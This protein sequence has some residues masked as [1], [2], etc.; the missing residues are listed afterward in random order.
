[1]SLQHFKIADNGK[2]IYVSPSTE[3]A[4]V[5]FVHRFDGIFPS[6]RFLVMNLNAKGFL[7]DIPPVLNYDH[8]T[9]RLLNNSKIV[10]QG[11]AVRTYIA[12]MHQSDL[13]LMIPLDRRQDGLEN[14]LP[15]GWTAVV[16]GIDKK[17]FDPDAM[18]S[19]PG[20]TPREILYQALWRKQLEC[21]LLDQTVHIYKAGSPPTEISSHFFD[22][23]TSSR[24]VVRFDANNSVHSVAWMGTGR[25][26]C[27][28]NITTRVAGEVKGMKVAFASRYGRPDRACKHVALLVEKDRIFDLEALTRMGMIQTPCIDELRH[29]KGTATTTKSFISRMTHDPPQVYFPTYNWY[30]GTNWSGMAK[31]DQEGRAKTTDRLFPFYM[32]VDDDNTCMVKYPL[33]PSKGKELEEL[34]LLPELSTPSTPSPNVSRSV[35]MGNVVENIASYKD[36]ST[37]IPNLDLFIKIPGKANRYG[38]LQWNSESNSSWI[39]ETTGSSGTSTIEVQ[40]DQI[41]MESGGVTLTMKGGTIDVT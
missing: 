16:H 7:R 8:A 19:G 32:K 27:G 37:K 13:E 25:L 21:H 38:R 23:G 40:E 10:E 28:S 30:E 1:M 5:D 18:K 34:I 6:A 14:M 31:K 35:S 11:N 9:W 36:G 41:T 24:S 22:T 39:L 26:L 2:L 3:D 20:R 4:I 12:Y 15:D 33:T 17:E 29:W